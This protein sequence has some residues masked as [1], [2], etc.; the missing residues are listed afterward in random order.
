SES[1]RSGPALVGEAA[2]LA[3]QDRLTDAAALVDAA[4]ALAPVLGGGYPAS[5][6]RARRLVHLG[7]RRRRDRDALAGFVRRDEQIE[8]VLE[9]LAAG[10]ADPWALHLLGPGGVG[11][12]M[13]VRYLASDLFAAEH[14]LPPFAVA[15]V[16]CDHIKPDSPAL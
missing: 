13:L 9:L 5:V 12:T 4:A 10:P 3:G 7:H 11:K 14:G 2:A 8:P 16:D 1:G 6:I 15:R